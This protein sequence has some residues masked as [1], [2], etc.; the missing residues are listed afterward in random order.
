M[1]SMQVELDKMLAKLKVSAD[2]ILTIFSIE[3]VV[4][5]KSGWVCENIFSVFF[6]TEDDFRHAAELMKTEAPENVVTILPKIDHKSITF[7]F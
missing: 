1:N 2:D 7:I 5:T 4:P 3:E 6:N